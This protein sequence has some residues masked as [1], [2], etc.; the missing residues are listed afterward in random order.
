MPPKFTVEE[1]S[2]YEA[3]DKPSN[4]LQAQSCASA[5][6]SQPMVDKRAAETGRKVNHFKFCSGY[7][8]IKNE[9]KPRLNLSEWDGI[10]GASRGW[11]L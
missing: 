3:T 8:G 10:E 9:S 5:G 11:N 4:A 6:D 7:L 1:R 2:T